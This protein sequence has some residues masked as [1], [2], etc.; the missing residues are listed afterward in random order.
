MGIAVLVS[1][2]L[3]AF[4]LISIRGRGQ[5]VARMSPISSLSGQ[6]NLIASLNLQK[7]PRLETAT[8]ARFPGF[9]MLTVVAGPPNP[10][11]LRPTGVAYTALATRIS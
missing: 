8:Q 5:V 6:G 4:V 10:T 3:R 9:E 2:F 11:V 1:S 7:T